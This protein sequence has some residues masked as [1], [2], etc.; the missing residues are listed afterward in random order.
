MSRRVWAVNEPTLIALNIDFVTCTGT[1]NVISDE[2]R[3]LS[4]NVR[5][6]VTLYILIYITLSY[7]VGQCSLLVAYNVTSPCGYM[8]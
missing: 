3:A 1:R 7:I 4:N 5:Y 2:Q 6:P 8:V